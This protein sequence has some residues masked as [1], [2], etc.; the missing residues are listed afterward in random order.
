[1]YSSPRF[2]PPNLVQCLPLPS[3]LQSVPLLTTANTWPRHPHPSTLSVIDFL[4]QHSEQ[5]ISFLPSQSS[6]C[7]SNIPQGMLLKDPE[8]IGRVL[9]RHLGQF[10][11]D[12]EMQARSLRLPSNRNRLAQCW[13]EPRHFPNIKLRDCWKD[14]SSHARSSRSMYADWFRFGLQTIPDLII[15]SRR[16]VYWL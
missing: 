14:V 16:H 5:N 7:R 13:R 11:I 10:G 6:Q 9:A 3:L 12:T 2:L 8:E 4:R 15:L 1:M